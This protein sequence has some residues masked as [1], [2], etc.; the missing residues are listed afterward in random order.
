MNLFDHTSH[1][2]LQTE[3]LLATVEQWLRDATPAVLIT[4]EATRGSVPR[5]QNSAIVVSKNAIAG[6]IGGGHLEWHAIKIAHR[7][8]QHSE[9]PDKAEKISLGPSLGQCCGGAVSLRFQ[10]LDQTHLEALKGADKPLFHLN[11]FG[12]GHVGQSLV[13]ALSEVPC[14]IR[15]VDERPAIFPLAVKGRTTVVVND[16]PGDEISDCRAGDFYLVMTHRHDRDFELVSKILAR[17]DAGYLGLIGSKTKRVRFDRRLQQRELEPGLMHCPI[18]QSGMGG[19]E[20]WRIALSVAA[21]LVNR[22]STGA[23]S[24]LR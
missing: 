7:L 23:K 10:A 6:T 12:A 24:G 22:A 9:P 11:L 2:G 18:G 17:A 21:D 14:T 16:A 19:K 20:P 8:L 4:V 3:N 13:N 1:S 15:W 5:E